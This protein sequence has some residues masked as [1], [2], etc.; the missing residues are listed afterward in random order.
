MNR[1]P[2]GGA[3]IVK[4]IKRHETLI[5]EIDDTAEPDRRPTGARRE[6]QNGPAILFRESIRLAAE[7]NSAPPSGLKPGPG[8]NY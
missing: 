4:E 7:P 6:G 2:H 3:A 5:V 8:L 1:R